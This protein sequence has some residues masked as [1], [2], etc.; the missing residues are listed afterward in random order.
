MLPGITVRVLLK[1]KDIFTA[2]SVTQLL[3]RYFLSFEQLL[4]VRISFLFINLSGHYT[5]SR[6]TKQTVNETCLKMFEDIQ[7]VNKRAIV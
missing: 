5:M 4:Y 2:S 6:A 1:R 3:L 7:N